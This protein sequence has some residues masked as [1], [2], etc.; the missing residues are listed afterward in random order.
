MP[1]LAADIV[2]VWSESSHYVRHERVTGAPR[3]TSINQLGLNQP[4]MEAVSTRIASFKKSKRVKNPEKLTST[5]ALKW[6]HPA[7]FQANP[8]TLAEAG[9]YYD[10]SYDD[11]DNVTCF[12]CGKQL[13]GWEEGDDPFLI[14]WGKC[15]QSCC[16]ASVRCG[17]LVDVDHS[18]RW[19]LNLL[20]HT[21]IDRF[22][23]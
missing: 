3:V 22:S 23:S 15:G 7:D 14:H 13:G 17:L 21:R 18:G 5:T 1:A 12:T 16:W 11:P 4:T 9:F 6:P 20:Y 2:V 8:E 10:P 19:G